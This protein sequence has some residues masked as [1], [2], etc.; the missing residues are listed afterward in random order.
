MNV[1]PELVSVLMTSYNREKYIA[2]AIESVIKQTY[3]NWELI[4]VDDQSNDDTLLI[5]KDFAKIDNRIKVYVN[6]INLGDYQNRNRAASYANG[7]FIKY[8]D[9]DD[10]M[11]SWCLDAMVNC[12][13]KHPEAAYGLISPSHI[14]LQKLYPILYK[15]QDAYY[16]YF[17]ADP[18]LIVGPTGS[19]IRT[20]YFRSIKG[21]S[22][23]PYIGDTELWLKLSAKWTMLVM[24][25]DLIWWREH[26]EQQSVYESKNDKVDK[27]RYDMIVNTLLSDECPL[28]KEWANVA[29]RNQKNIRIRNILS[30]NIL[31]FNIW[32]MFKKFTEFNF[33]IFDLIMALKKNRKPELIERFNN[34]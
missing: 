9:A 28:I 21:Y 2:E 24:P 20:D 18:I 8:L 5:A 1:K 12:M 11:Y 4:I 32:G 34:K 10:I 23:L 31:R 7:E 22:G 6:E 33:S 16:S 27:M 17:F 25:P 13:K 26:D 14:Y 19:I 30:K 29:I 3:F 15:P